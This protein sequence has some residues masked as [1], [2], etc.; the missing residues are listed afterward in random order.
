[1]KYDFDYSLLYERMAEYRHSQ[2]SLASAIPISRT[3]INHKLQGKNLFTQWEIKRICDI[4][5]IPPA[6][7]GKYFFKQNVQKTVQII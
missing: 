7:V 4:L 5:D 1:M 2:S 3:S 6:K